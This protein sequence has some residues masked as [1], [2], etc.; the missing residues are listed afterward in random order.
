MSDT[1]LMFVLD[2]QLP[3][4]RHPD[5]PGCLEES[6]LFNA[7]SDTYLPLLR[8][9][10]ALETSGV[11]FSLAIA[12]SPTLCEMLTDPLL[13]ARYVDNLDRSIEF[14]LAELDRC[15]SSPE[16]REL[17]KNH[18]DHLQINRRDYVEIYERDILKKFDYFATRGNI[19]ILATTATACFLPLYSDI[20]EAINAQIETGLL[21]YRKHFTAIP[22]GF[23]VP[24][25]AWF[26]GLENILKAYGFQYTILE[27]HGLLFADPVPDTGLFAPALCPNGFPVY[28]RDRLACLEV[29]DPRAGCATAEE[30]LDVDKDIG[31]ELDED[32]LSP[33][34]DVKLGRRITGFRY[35]SHS[36]L[37]GELRAFYHPDKAHARATADAEAF[38]E[39]RAAA[40]AKASSFLEG[41][42]VS[43]VCAFP[44]QFFGGG[45]FEG[46]AW[47]EHAFRAVASRQD[48]RF[49][50]PSAGIKQGLTGKKTVPCVS[51]W[52]DNGYAENVLNS[53]ND[54]M[55]PFVRKATE[56]MIDLAER[57]P[58]DSGLKER[59]L[60]MASRE[61]LLAQS[62][63]WSLMMNEKDRVEYARRRFEDAIKAFT[64]VYESL[65]SN[66]IS[67][68][69]L[70][71]I[72]K[73]DNLF[74][75]INYRV[76]SRKK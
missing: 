30:Y 15:S 3:F 51:S 66:F 64:V 13:R 50:L 36:R 25:M 73:T 61:I 69:W 24:A 55:Y 6:L 68:E 44:A 9:C 32:T 74:S 75:N 1:S 37:S 18:L 12:F 33:L 46:I 2:A 72:E 23:W 20:T 65:G 58:D 57:F 70:T 62:M 19:E 49:A 34:F 60:C 28:A 4:I 56:R 39:R 42:P 53:A 26:P 54:W 35:W 10:T 5:T 63:D 16:T 59:A 21:T 11:P 47:L 31:F 7:I 27:S 67:T 43:L 71:R 76:F 17:I 8:S 45:W 40:L 14:G 52:H 29:I 48:I 41:A 22:A 38:I